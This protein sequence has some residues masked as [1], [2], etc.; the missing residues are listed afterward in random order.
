MS[1]KWF[2]LDLTEAAPTPVGCRVT[3]VA[4]MGR[5][6]ASPSPVPEGDVP[7]RPD[8]PD[9]RPLGVEATPQQA[10]SSAS[11]RRARGTAAGS[12][13]SSSRPG[14]ILVGGLVDR[15]RLDRPGRPR[16][17]RR[18]GAVHPGRRPD[19]D[20]RVGRCRSSSR[21]CF[22]VIGALGRLSRNAAD[23]RHRD[24]LRLARPRHAAD[25]PAD[26][27]LPRPAPVRDRAARRSSCG[28]LRRSRSTTAP[29]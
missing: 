14:S 3:D 6:T 9:V 8:R 18:V 21:R 24:A 7:D 26:L 10:S 20:L 28:D 29:T 5:Q 27:L 17:H 12:A 22:A 16:L 13:S 15:D 23:L 25:H 1:E 11:R 4:S 2:G 19:H